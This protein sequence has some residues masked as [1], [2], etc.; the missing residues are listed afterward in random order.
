MKAVTATLASN[1]YSCF[2][3]LWS[4]RQTHV[5]LKN[6]TAENSVDVMEK[7]AQML[8]YRNVVLL[9]EFGGAAG[10]L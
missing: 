6:V 9:V 2:V 10:V 8:L 5:K 4:L 1:C 3:L 7:Y